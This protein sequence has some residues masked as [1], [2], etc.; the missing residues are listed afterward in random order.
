MARAIKITSVSGAL[1]VTITGPN[2]GTPVVYADSQLVNTLTMPATVADTATTAFWLP[3]P[4]KYTLSVKT[5]GGTE[6]AADNNQP[7]TVDLETDS[8]VAALN[9]DARTLATVAGDSGHSTAGGSAASGVGRTRPQAQDA[10]GLGLWFPD[11][12]G[13]VYDGVTDD[14]AAIQAAIDACTAAGGG[15]VYITGAEQIQGT[16]SGARV[17]INSTIIVKSSVTLRGVGPQTSFTGTANPMF[18]L[19]TST[20]IP[21]RIS[22]RDINLQSPVGVGIDTSTAGDTGG[23]QLGWTR[24][25]VENVTVEDAGSHA[26]NVANGGPIETR[27][28]NCVTLRAAGHGF[29]I[30]STDCMFIGCTAAQGAS[31]SFYGFNVAGGNNKFSACK[32]YGNAGGNWL[33]GGGGRHTF[34]ACESQDAGKHGWDI[35]SGNNSLAGCLSDSDKY[36][37]FFFEGGSNSA[38]GCTAMYGGGGSGQVTPVGFHFASGVT[39]CV[40]TGTTVCAVPVGGAVQ[41][42]HVTINGGYG[43]QKIA[44]AASYTPA[45]YSGEVIDVEVLTGNI[46]INNPT[47]FHDGQRMTIRL[48]QD[49]TGG[50]TVTWGG[51]FAVASAMPANPNAAQSYSFIYQNFRWTEQGASIAASMTT[52]SATFTAADSAS[53]V[54]NADSPSLAWTTASGTMGVS[55]NSLYNSAGGT[56]LGYYDWGVADGYATITVTTHDAS[57]NEGLLLRYVDASNYLVLQHDGLAQVIAGVNRGL[58]PSLN[59][60]SGDVI[61]CYMRGANLVVTKNG[62]VVGAATIGFPY[63]SSGTMAAPPAALLSATKHGA[64]INGTV[65]RLD[66][67]TFDGAT[68]TA[69]ATPQRYDQIQAVWQSGTIAETTT[70]N[71]TLGNVGLASGTLRA[72][73]VGLTAG[74]VITAGN[75]INTASISAVTHIWY[76][77][78]DS[79]GKVLAVTADDTSGVWG[80]NAT[81]TLNFTSQFIAPTTGL[82]YF[83]VCAVGTTPPTIPGV[84]L[85]NTAYTFAPMIAP[86]VASQTTPPSVG[87]TLTLVAGSVNPWGWLT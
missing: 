45:P 84:S 25:T 4:G 76:V 87:T 51:A 58:T 19:P 86:T 6:I 27:W 11:A 22:I 20:T 80:V 16:T 60:V 2:G 72:G 53:A 65:A 18:A 40:V 81:K 57:G 31:G 52:G 8:S 64:T 79:A 56:A 30:G 7:R 82:Y 42:N 50:R 29:N 14:S 61:G 36:A 85:S 70:R 54:P 34:A 35:P 21:D 44:Y 5:S 33:V 49:A 74:Q 43:K 59:S 15:T 38:Q 9:Y 32:A 3:G 37:G 55:S 47:S 63:A 77:I 48:R 39:G 71:Y 17:K 62:A 75:F 68:V 23:N 46:T 24:F 28:I 12:H 67:L 83:G 1:T 66:N 41:G 26:F 13:A 69:K 73:P 78:M 10:P